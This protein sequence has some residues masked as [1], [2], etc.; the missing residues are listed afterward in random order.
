MMQSLSSVMH[1]R[2]FASAGKERRLSWEKP[3]TMLLLLDS[4]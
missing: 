1:A 2:T 3:A 4:E